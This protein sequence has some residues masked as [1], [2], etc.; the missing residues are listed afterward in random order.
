MFIFW[1]I[2]KQIVGDWSSI[3]NQSLGTR[4]RAVW[5]RSRCC[6]LCAS[7]CKQ[8]CTALAPPDPKPLNPEPLNPKPQTLPI[9][10]TTRRERERERERERARES[11]RER[12]R[13]ETETET[14]T[15]TGTETETETLTESESERER[16]ITGV[17]TIT[18]N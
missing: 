5:P 1:E 7:L 8:R 12:E 10:L 2:H 4:T 6:L 14:E 16:D 15:G 17:A 11:E 3:P 13:A 18:K 9:V